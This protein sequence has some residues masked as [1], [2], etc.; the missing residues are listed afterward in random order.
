MRKTSK[1]SGAKQHVVIV[2]GGFAGL[3]ATQS[4]KRV[5]VDVTLVD[6]RNF[7]LFQPLLYQVAT[8]GLSPADI[9]SPLRGILRRQKNVRVLQGEVTDVNL[10]GRQ[11]RI[12]DE[13]LKFDVLIVATGATHHYFGN[14]GWR[15][16]APGLKTIEDALDIRRR[17]FSAFERAELE[18]DQR[19][20][21]SLL[22]FVVVGGGPTGV[23]LAGAVSELAHHTLLDNF[24]SID[25]A[26][27]KIL[28]VEAADR[29]LPPYNSAS[30]SHAK[31]SLEKLGV[32]VIT[33]AMV[34]DVTG[35]SV[36]LGSDGETEV[37]ESQTI[38]WGAGVKG[39]PLG[40]CLAQQT[41]AELDRQGRISVQ[42]DLSLPGHPDVFVIGDLARFAHQTDN[43]LPGVAPVAMQQGRYVATLLAKRLRGREYRP[44]RYRD[45]G[46]MAVIGRAA[47]VAELGRVRF[48]G[49]VAWLMWLFIHLINLVEFENR[50]LVVLQWGWNYFTRNRSARLITN[51]RPPTHQESS[52]AKSTWREPQEVLESSE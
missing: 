7:H 28:L 29:I 18:R 43:P 32:T 1:V 9:A 45:L 49:F 5:P 20:R 23:E 34:K 48:H 46:S 15:K 17:I 41:G 10:D 24:R 8:G 36:T 39:S 14:E 27:A 33:G 26:S 11:L 50:L 3:Y 2:G 13:Q 42:P 19:R 37:I 6:R 12:G 25:P 22:T 52:L 31:R 21:E 40:E 30:S 51:D 47:A 16:H 4:L 44:F 35:Q 38:L